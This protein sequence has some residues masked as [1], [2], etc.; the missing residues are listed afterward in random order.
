MCLCELLYTH[1]VCPWMKIANGVTFIKSD[2]NSHFYAAVFLLHELLLTF[3]T[4]KKFHIMNCVYI[5]VCAPRRRKASQSHRCSTI[6]ILLARRR[7]AFT[8]RERKWTLKI[9]AHRS[10][11]YVS[12]FAPMLADNTMV[13][14]LILR[15]TF[16][17][18]IHT[19]LCYWWTSWW[20][21]RY[22]CPGR[23]CSL[24]KSGQRSSHTYF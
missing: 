2:Q 17:L 10:S 13:S 16:F 3:Y 19:V 18:L 14:P 22:Q 12:E 15:T 23:K 7:L 5:C 21:T 20:V 8:A 24:F 6:V 1:T 11:Q 4:Q 9:N